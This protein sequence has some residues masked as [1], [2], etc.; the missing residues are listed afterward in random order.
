MT[1]R[2]TEAHTRT[3]F[4][5][6]VED[7]RSFDGAVIAQRYLAPYLAFHSP[8]SIQAFTSQAEIARYF[9]GILDEYRAQGCH[10]CR[11]T[12]LA[13]HPLG[14]GCVLATVTWELLDPSLSVI[15]AWRESYN[16]CLVGDRLMV[17]ASTDHP[18]T[19]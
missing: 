4:D 6:F 15:S 16:L 19:A 7:F 18:P 11:Y 1:P 12:D 17:F 9:Q 8:T 10:S 5:T 3:F 13:T 14:E 2:I